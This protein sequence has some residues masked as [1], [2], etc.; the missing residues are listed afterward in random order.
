MLLLNFRISNQFTIYNSNI[1]PV[2]IQKTEFIQ[3]KNKPNKNNIDI[4]FFFFS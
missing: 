2:K 3:L 4:V 1:I